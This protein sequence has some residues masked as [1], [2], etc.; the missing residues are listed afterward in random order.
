MP[1]KIWWK[2]F[3]INSSPRNLVKGFLQR[4][5]QKYYLSELLQIEF[6]LV[7]LPLFLQEN[8]RKCF[9]VFYSKFLLVYFQ[10][11]VEILIQVF[12]QVFFHEFLQKLLQRF[13]KNP[14]VFSQKFLEWLLE[15]FF[16]GFVQLFLQSFSRNSC[17]DFFKDSFQNSFKDIFSNFSKYS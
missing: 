13:F 9:Q 17:K 4:I 12:N 5:H 6:L 3:L 8:L 7:K 2:I 1:T 11:S 15:K 16:Q 10:D 14:P